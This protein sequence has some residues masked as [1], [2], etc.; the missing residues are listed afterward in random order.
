MHNLTA[1]S[2]SRP[3]IPVPSWSSQRFFPGR[4]DQIREA[5]A[6]VA[7]LLR[8]SALA[9][10]AVLLIS[11]MAANACLYSASGGPGGAF[12]VRVDGFPGH[13]RAEVEDQ[14][15]AW[16]GD[17]ST[18]QPPHGLYLLQALSASC[19]TRPGIHGWVTW[20]TLAVPA[21]AALP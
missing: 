8:G 7:R 6:F 16:D 19:G 3:P 11:E 10:D 9:A 12:T 17:L 14:G 21:S 1:P 13:I 15:S 4:A 20:Y 2:A 18:A 5:R